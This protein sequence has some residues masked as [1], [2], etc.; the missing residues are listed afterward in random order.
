MNSTLFGQMVHAVIGRTLESLVDEL[1]QDSLSTRM[2]AGAR[3]DR[4]G[5]VWLQMDDGSEIRKRRFMSRR[6]AKRWTRRFSG[7]A[8][9]DF[10]YRP[11]MPVSFIVLDTVI[12]AGP[13]E[14]GAP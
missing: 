6:V 12:P 11:V 7:M 2:V 14:G 5:R 1:V 10:A 9:V 4:R 8:I 3:I 13:D